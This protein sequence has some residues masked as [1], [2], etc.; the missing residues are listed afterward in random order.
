MTTL[1]MVAD[2]P[3]DYLDTNISNNDREGFG[4]L[5]KKIILSLIWFYYNGVLMDKTIDDENM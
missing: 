4:T 5:R 3:K 2:E 1:E